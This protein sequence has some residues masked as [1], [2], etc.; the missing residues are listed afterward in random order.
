L[1]YSE[2]IIIDLTEHS[3]EKDTADGQ[4]VEGPD[5]KPFEQRIDVPITK[6]QVAEVFHVDNKAEEKED[7]LGL[8]KIKKRKHGEPQ[9]RKAGK[10]RI[11]AQYQENCRP[12]NDEDSS[13]K[14]KTSVDRKKEAAHINSEN[15]K[16]VDNKKET[17]QI[18]S[19]N[20]K[21][22]D[23][24]NED[25]KITS[26]NNK[27]VDNFKEAENVTLSSEKKERKD[28]QNEKLD[29]ENELYPMYHFQTLAKGADKSVFLHTPITVE[30]LK[31]VNKFI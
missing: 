18:T 16:A 2:K 26:K 3:D 25:E 27:P 1:S 22:V 11:N 4:K 23:N 19:K 8:G 14:K 13:S 15:N 7:C 20:K 24:K 12:D 6:K 29:D 9:V 17:E 21:A 5:L 30:D 10:I 31:K 28:E